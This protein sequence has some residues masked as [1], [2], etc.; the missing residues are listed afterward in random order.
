[1]AHSDL[2]A[3]SPVAGAVGCWDRDM[4]VVDADRREAAVEDTGCNRGCLEKVPV[5]HCRQVSGGKR[6][7]LG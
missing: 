1:M 7:M 5:N 4:A 6:Y 2:A 3:G